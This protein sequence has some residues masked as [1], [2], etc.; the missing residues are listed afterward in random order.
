MLGHLNPLTQFISQATKIFKGLGF[1]IV[2]SP[3]V[4]TVE[5]NFD[6]LNIPKEHPARDV[7]DTFYL[8]DGRV[9]R[10]HTSPGQLRAME[11]RKPPVRVII[12]GR[13]FRRE[14]TDAN[15]ETTFYQLEGFAIDKS[16]TM[17][18][19]IGTLDHF[20]RKIFG[21]SIKVRFVPA[22]FP[23]TE[24]SMEVAIQKDKK[25]IEILGSGMIHP[26][27]LRN[28]GLDPKKWQGFA[29]GMGIDRLMMLYYGIDDIRLSYSGDLRFLK[30]F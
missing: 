16:L 1:E 17:A 2:Q 19:L 26:V 7:W 14:A 27:V 3:E 18:E 5:Y 29:F 12:P 20:I 8:S 10:T 23:F 13:T 9:L 21:P 25:W 24:P 4:E 15:H 28:M 6:L 11:S 30:Q 22:F